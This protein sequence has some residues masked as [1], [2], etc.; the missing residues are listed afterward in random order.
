M[1][2]LVITLVSITAMLAGFY[3][4]ARHFAEPL[5]TP[6]VQSVSSD[7]LIG[8]LRP[9]FKLGSNKG[10]LVSPTDFAGKTILINFWATWCAPCREE[11]PMLMDLQRVHGASGL[12]V[13]GIA[14]DDAKQVNH[15]VSTYGITYPI[16]VGEADVFETSAAY[17]NSE[18]VLPYSVL[19]DKNGIILWNYAGIIKHEKI[20]SLLNEFL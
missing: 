2:R 5:P 19:I 7:N 9:D 10:E 11:M 17:G 15:F 1:R 12:Q 8:S 4:S 14:L 20:N 13:V 18:G 16:L 6:A 3:I